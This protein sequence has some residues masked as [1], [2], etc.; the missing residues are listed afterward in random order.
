MWKLAGGSSSACEHSMLVWAADCLAC[1]TVQ[2]CIQT[3][4]YTPPIYLKN[5]LTESS[6]P[7]HGSWDAIC[8]GVEKN[9]SMC[10]AQI[11]TVS[12]ELTVLTWCD[13]RNAK[14]MILGNVF[15]LFLLLVA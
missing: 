14:K 4:G 1:L 9:L 6:K 3:P 15:L 8:P 12:I 10:C 5:C 7:I 2:E 11:I 13:M